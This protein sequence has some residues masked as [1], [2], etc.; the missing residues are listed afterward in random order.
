MPAKR[1]IDFNLMITH[2]P[3]YQNYK[4]AMD[5]IT[6][7]LGHVV[8]IDAIQSRILL[9]VNDPYNALE[10]LTQYLP[11]DTP[12]LKIIPVDEV[13][14]PY[15]EDVANVVWDLA[16]SKIPKESTYRITL[17]GRHL[18][19][20]S[21]GSIAHR[22][23]AIK[24]IASK[25]DRPVNLKNY[26]WIVYIKVLRLHRRERASITVAPTKYIFSRHKA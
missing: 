4:W 9:K 20:K 16:D 8:V 21:N 14:D 10:L 15:V 1:S 22:E 18:Y 19:W 2:E 11:R 12:I 13:V 26:E 7:I 24:Y 25:I 3:S 17:E 23:E 6:S 5:Q